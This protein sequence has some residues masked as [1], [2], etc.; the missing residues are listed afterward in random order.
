MCTL[1]VLDRLISGYPLIAAA[2]RDEFYTRPASPPQQLEVDPWVV[3][4][5]DEQAGGTWIGVSSG[6]FFAGLT[7]RPRGEARDPGRPSRGEITLRALR[8]GRLAPVLSQ[9]SGLDEIAYD[10][11]HLL[12]AGSDGAAVVAH[13]PEGYARRLDPGVHV[14][15]NKGLSLPD[16]PKARRIGALLGDARNL[17]SAE[18]AL[19]ALEGILTDHAGESVLDRICIHT[20]H[21]GTRSATLLAIHGEDAGRSI[22]RHTEGP[23]CES[24]WKDVSDLLK[25]APSWRGEGGSS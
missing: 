19:S 21:Y 11:F 24:P 1:I 17:D 16:D 8:A 22:Y 7:N 18:S 4:P 3:G 5:R 14:L 23:S 2:N 6:G 25:S 10:G 12:C 9:F 20:E 15:T 13:G